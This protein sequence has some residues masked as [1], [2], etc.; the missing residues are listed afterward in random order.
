MRNDAP[1]RTCSHWN[2]ERHDNAV[3]DLNLGNFLVTAI[4]HAGI[5]VRLRHSDKSIVCENTFKVGPA[6]TNIFEKLGKYCNVIVRC[7]RH[8]KW[9]TGVDTV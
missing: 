7:R 4:N 1:G 8:V 5:L 2:T 9:L 3:N 6:V